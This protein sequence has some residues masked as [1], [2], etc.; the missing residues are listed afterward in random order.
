MTPEQLSEKVYERLRQ[1]L[2]RYVDE[3]GN[4][5]WVRPENLPR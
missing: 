2:V 3:K 1:N 4:V 5:W